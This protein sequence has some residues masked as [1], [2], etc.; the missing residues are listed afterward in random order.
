MS[1]RAA[2]RLTIFS[3][4]TSFQILW[5]QYIFDHHDAI[6][7]LY[8]SKYGKRDVLFKAQVFLEKLTYRLLM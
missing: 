2:I 3:G 5:S 1:F 7:E 8:L 4:R 6:P